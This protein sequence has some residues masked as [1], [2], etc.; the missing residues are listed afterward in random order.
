M[1]YLDLTVS[2][3]KL[4]IVTDSDSEEGEH[5]E[6]SEEAKTSTPDWRVFVCELQAD[7]F[8]L[9]YNRIYDSLAALCK[10]R[11]GM[12]CMLLKRRYIV[13]AL[14]G[15]KTETR[16]H[17]D[18]KWTAGTLIQLNDQVNFLTVRVDGIEKEGE[19]IFRYSFTVID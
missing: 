9:E 13:Q 11:P 19:G 8:L 18:K 6:L 12:P 10:R 17:Y 1:F 4:E 16:R 5:E 15:I 14:M 2:H 7:A 3:D